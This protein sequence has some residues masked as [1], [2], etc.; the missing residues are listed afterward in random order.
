MMPADSTF[1]NIE[2]HVLKTSIKQQCKASH[3]QWYLW[4]LR[5][6]KSAPSIAQGAV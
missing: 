3:W 6:I 1:A 2:N 4:Q 5:G